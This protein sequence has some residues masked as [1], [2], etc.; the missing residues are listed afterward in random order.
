[1]MAVEDEE[2]LTH[3]DQ[4]EGQGEA[5]HSGGPASIETILTSALHKRAAKK[6]G[7]KLGKNKKSNLDSKEELHEGNTNKKKKKSKTV[8]GTETHEKLELGLLKG[9]EHSEESKKKEETITEQYGETVAVSQTLA[10]DG[11]EK[12]EDE[13]EGEEHAKAI[14]KADE[15][16]SPTR[17]YL[18]AVSVPKKKPMRKRKKTTQDNGRVLGVTI[19]SA[20]RLEGSLLLFPHPV[21]QVYI[22][23]METGQFLQKSSPE[24]KVT[25]Y[26][27]RSEVDYILPIMTSPFD[28]KKAR[29]I[30]CRWE[31]QLVFNEPPEHFTSDEPQVL[32]FFQLMDFPP[33]VDNSP[34]IPE[35]TG[36]DWVTFAWAFLKVKGTNGHV[37]IGEQLRLQMWRPR[38]SSKVGLKD[39]HS[40]WKSGSRT[41][42]PSTLHVTLQEV[43]IPLN[44][45]PT[46]RS[47]IATQPEGIPV[48]LAQSL[49]HSSTVGSSGSLAPA[50]HK[51]GVMWGR[52]P[53]QS[54]RIGSFVKYCFP[55]SEKGCLVVKFSHDGLRIA[56]GNHKEVFIYD[57]L[58]GHLEQALC[59]HLGLI[60][61]ICW[62]TDDGHI[63][64]ASADSTARI[65]KLGSAEIHSQSEVLA[66]PSYVYVARFVP[67]TVHV[68]V[69]GCYDHVLRVWTYSKKGGYSVL[70]E[71]TNHLSFVN[72]LCFNGE[73]DVLYSGDKQGMIFVW[74][75]KVSPKDK[76]KRKTK[77]LSLKHEAKVPDIV[78]NT[79]NSITAHPG[80]FRLLVHTRDSQLRLV[81]HQH[82]TVTHNLRGA[83]NVREQLRSCISPCG[84]W[85]VSGSEDGGLFVWNSDTGEMAASVMDLPLYGTVSC[86]D[87]HPHDHMVAVCSYSSESP[88]LILAHTPNAPTNTNLSISVEA[89][90][91]RNHYSSLR[92]S[93]PQQSVLQGLD[94][95]KTVTSRT[96]VTV[97]KIHK[98]SQEHNMLSL[99]N[100]NSTF[101]FSSEEKENSL[102]TMKI[103]E[104]KSG[105]HLMMAQED[106]ILKKLDSV[107][108]MAT[109][110]PLSF[111]MDSSRKRSEGF[112]AQGD[113]ATVLYDYTG[114][115]KREL[116][117]RQGDFVLV[118]QEINA[119]WWLVQTADGRSTGLVPAPYLNKLPHRT[120]ETENLEET[121]KV[122]VVP[123]AHGDISFLSDSEDAPRPARAR[124][125]KSRASSI[126]SSGTRKEE[127]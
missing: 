83:L 88:V 13:S 3:K 36:R 99:G 77:I 27:E 87:F 112:I 19:H 12:D 25:S 91:T 124:R 126:L 82:W 30:Y 114:S 41:K 26:Y 84:T 11:R 120:Q 51:P 38:R 8:K 18:R 28:I 108:K 125:H 119:D 116:S 52:K 62:S 70:Q 98:I 117:L 37:N 102:F 65:W 69:S 20:D 34:G 111:T 42:Y 110:E 71:I 79:I 1:M 16:A 68:A 122:L 54:C 59:G 39:L 56:C 57:V 21:V 10:E 50:A 23:N 96:S 15:V 22:C 40:W 47:M 46:L 48:D 101:C 105:H 64:T 127:T 94:A 74:N 67:G 97:E 78:G 45:E 5:R 14:S 44:P 55:H 66:H 85:V 90:S 35:S 103:H 9:S 4:S 72:A 109:E 24:R 63:L 93:S 107:L 76:S 118:V 80:G 121:G 32:V 61:D 86:V 106:A 75:V 100:C 95:Y 43:V 29:S 58:A 123:S 60:Y 31:E 33:S 73:G 2:P 113:L 104:S 92:I 89:S 53:N 6:L 115:D 81:N 17:A 7:K 49:E